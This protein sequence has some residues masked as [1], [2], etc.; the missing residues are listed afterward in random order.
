[1]GD[2]FIFSFRGTSIS[3]FADRDKFGGPITLQLDGT[4]YTVNNY[5][6]RLAL[7]QNLWTSPTLDSGDHQMFVVNTGGT[8]I[9]LDQLVVTSNDGSSNIAPANLGPGA[10]SVPAGATVVDD[11]DSSISYNG[12]GWQTGTGGFLQGSMRYTNSTGDSC[13]FAFA[14]TQ[15]FYF[16]EDFNS[17][18]PVDISIDGGSSTRLTDP[19]NGSPKFSQRL[20]WTSPILDNGQHT[21]TIMHAGNSDQYAGIDFFMYHSGSGGSGGL[22]KSI[23]TAA[24]VGAGVG[25]GVLIT[26]IILVVLIIRRRRKG[27]RPQPP[28]DRPEVRY[29]ATPVYEPYLEKEGTLSPRPQS[30]LSYGNG[31]LD[32]PGLQGVTGETSVHT[33]LTASGYRGFP[34]VD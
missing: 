17:A 9:G 7:Q 29:T 11:T 5:A 21:V 8:L 28:P 4:R 32:S 14:G 20:A 33:N 16:V 27:S 22:K 30:T 24:I 15:F 3:W 26:F 25:G 6:P 2:G 18:A 19:S 10:S 31:G 12:A 13:T 34:E 1:M 23:P